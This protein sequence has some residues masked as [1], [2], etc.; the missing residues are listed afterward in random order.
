MGRNTKVARDA[1]NRLIAE[2]TFPNGSAATTTFTYDAT[3]ALN[4]VADAAGNAWTYHNNSR[5]LRVSANDPD[6]GQ[7]TYEYYPNGL[8][9]SQRDAV[10][11]VT[12]FT[13]DELLRRRT[14]TNTTTTNQV[15]HIAWTYDEAREGY[16]N[17]GRLTSLS[18]DTGSTQFEYD[19]AGNAPRRVKTINGVRYQFTASYD[20][21]GRLRWATY[22]DGT[23]QGPRPTH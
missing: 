22:P 20:E 9:R 15:S 13:Y 23:T 18:D 6:L 1:Q 7:W 2:T 3:G 12:A 10:G 16:A 17:I 19:L 11:N 14:A 4:S 5:G 8:V 21:V